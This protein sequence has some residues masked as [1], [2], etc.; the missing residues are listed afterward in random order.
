MASIALKARAEMIGIEGGVEGIRRAFQGKSAELALKLPKRG[1]ADH[2][3]GEAV[4][5]GDFTGDLRLLNALF[6]GESLEAIAFP[7]KPEVT[8]EKNGGK[9]HD[10]P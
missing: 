1:R 7:E 3:G 10:H 5:A 8:D 4:A 2:F 9:E 6:M